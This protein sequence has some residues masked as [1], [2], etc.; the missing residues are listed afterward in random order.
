M[1]HPEAER[2]VGALLGAIGGADAATMTSLLAED[3]RWWFPPS[4]AA[5]HGAGHPVVGR[6]A[7]MR[8]LIPEESAFLEGTTNYEVLHLLVDGALVVA[9][10]VR[11]GVVRGGR[12]YR[13]E[14]VFLLRVEAGRIIEVRHGMDTLQASTPV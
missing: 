11:T 8:Q 10:F 12:S 9:H 7:V 1:D 5:R 3:V 2:L 13:V 14:Y 4:V 6:E